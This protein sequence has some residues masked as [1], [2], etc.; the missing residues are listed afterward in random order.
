MVRANP[1]NTREYDDGRWH[2]EFYGLSTDTKPTERLATGS[3]F[4]EVNTGDAY[5]F[6]EVSE[7][8]IKAGG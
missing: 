7:T 5:F 8:W 1:A 4:I 3:L 2:K 6:D